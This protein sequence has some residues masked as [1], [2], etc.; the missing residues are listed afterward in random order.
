MHI[1]ISISHAILRGVLLCLL[2]PIFT[3]AQGKVYLVLGSDTALWD[4]MDVALYRC[5]YNLNLYT[6]TQENTY[7]VMNEVFRSQYKDSY[8]TP[9]K[10]TWWMMAGNIFR[11]ADNT[12]VPIPN[13]MTLY[14]MK[15]YH[16]AAI[17]R[18]G[19]ELTLHYH[20]FTW[21]DYNN[22]GKYYWNQAKN[23]TECRNDFDYTVAQFL[24]EENV[25]PVSFRSGWHAMDNDWQRY[26][27]RILPFSLHN[28]YPSIRADS[29]EPIDNVYDWSKA[30]SLFIP[31]HPSEN[32]YQLTGQG[33]GWNVRSIYM[34]SMSQ[35]LMDQIFT[36]AA[37]G[38][39]QVVCIWAHLPET[40]FLTNI[41]RIDSIAHISAKKVPQAPFV[42]CTAVEAMQRWLKTSDTTPPQLSIGE[43]LQ[44][45]KVTFTVSTNEPI[46]QAQPFV[47]V[48]DIYERILVLNCTS[49]GT[50]SWQTITPFDRATLAKV[51]IAVTD[52]LGNLSKQY[53]KYLPDDL[54]LDNLD[55]AYEEVSSGWTT[56]TSPSW[57]T[58]AR[59]AQ[60]T[61]QMPAQIRWRTRVPVTGL[62]NMYTQIPVITNPADSIIF[63][64]WA[65]Q[66]CVDSVLFRQSL[67]SNTW[68]YLFTP[69]VD[70]TQDV[71]VEMIAPMGRNFGKSIAA[72][73]LKISAL[74][75]ERSL[76]CPT[77]VVDL[78]T[79]R[80]GDTLSFTISL[81]NTGRLS[82]SVN[83]VSSLQQSIL[84]AIT[85]PLIIPPMQTVVLPLRW[86]AGALGGF[87]DSLFIQSN[88][89]IQ[90]SYPV[91]VLAAIER[92]FEIV[93]NEDSTH[94]REF[95]QW[96]T[97]N[98]QAYGTSS[99]YSALTNPPG[100]YA[101]FITRLRYGGVYDILQIIPKTVNGAVK[102]LYIIS[103]NGKVLDSLYRDQ[104][105]NSGSWTSLGRYRFS[106]QA[107]AS[108][109]IVN[110]GAS[111]E[112]FC[113]R[114][115][116]IKWS[117]AGESTTSI[118]SFS[119][120]IPAEFL[121]LPNYPNPFNSATTI[122]FLVP[123]KSQVLLRVYD[124][125]G[126]A[127]ATLADAVITP[128][129]YQSQ[130]RAETLASGV[131][132]VRMEARQVDGEKNYVLMTQKVLL[133]R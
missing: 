88:D 105:T 67:P 91:V 26:L 22:D 103:E 93:D 92:Y 41:A 45:G 102:A 60:I 57:G 131:Y 98:A 54:Y 29:T 108:V 104:N 32:N 53:L 81:T 34:A 70:S 14:L 28:A 133:L 59:R 21:T 124:A 111:T 77:N 24:L 96:L 75:K 37:S 71:T 7:K 73:V 58:D 129:V 68:V 116:A 114:A 42:Y 119:E 87:R 74:V 69:R 125:L 5:H 83:A 86:K 120:S 9:V 19:D 95:G 99:R 65:G 40:D 51:G 110:T 25:F 101:Q 39:D 128:G 132:F 46:F 121:L 63:K 1:V 79:V 56:M 3:I 49:T 84:P 27:N 106:P 30:S 35:T 18:W 123:V 90:P 61:S 33:K 127:V 78:G 82:L 43:V 97:S 94:Y 107:E 89:P 76:Y 118:Q 2:L 12:N 47:A 122:R 113:L 16:G 10:L 55:P 15:K 66:Q 62:V 112:V 44:N 6:Q 126:R 17:Q 117:I 11:Y 8:G 64:V 13:I 23:F 72:D 115:D 109:K 50:N 80:Q 100:A 36:R 48:K 20:T 85:L 31:F 52:T 4:N 38:T 130:W